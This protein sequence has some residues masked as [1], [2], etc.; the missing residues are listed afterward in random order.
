MMHLNRLIVS[1]VQSGVH[2][3]WLPGDRAW[4]RSLNL[5]NNQIKLKLK[6]NRNKAKVFIDV[7]TESS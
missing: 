7:Q 4:R 5:D 6:L 3:D 1:T 2:A